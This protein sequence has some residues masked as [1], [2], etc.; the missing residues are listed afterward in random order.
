[1]KQ[2]PSVLVIDD[3]ENMLKM[4]STLLRDS[5]EVL[6]CSSGEEGL[7]SFRKNPTDLVVTDIRMPDVT[8]MEIL[9]SVKRISPDTEV[10]LM[11]AYAQVSQ[12][13][14]AMKAGAY[15]YVTKPF[16]P[17]DMVL[18]LQ[19]ALER[20]RL[21]ERTA[22]LEKEVEKR[23]GFSEIIGES[24]AMQRA[25]ELARKAVASDTTV[26]LTGES[27]TGKELF[28]R[29]IHYSGPRHK[30]RF[31][32]INCAAMPK[33]LIESE[34]FGHVK[35]AFSGASRDKPGLFE[36]ADGGTLLLDEITELPHDMQAKINR[37]LEQ[38]EVRRVGDTRDRPV[39]VRVIA[40]SNHDLNSATER[41]M[42]REDLYFRLNVFPIHLPPLR[43]REGDVPLLL[44]HFMREFAGEDAG[45]YHIEPEA[46]DLLLRYSWPG[47]VR[48]LR[49]AIERALALCEDKRITSDLF[50]L[51]AGGEL[52]ATAVAADLPY[53][54]AMDRMTAQ[55]QREYLLA[56]LKKYD[57]NVTRAAEHAGIERESFHR[58]M[59]KCSVSSDDLKPSGGTT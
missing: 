20:K 49:N 56:V 18:T 40:S 1:M 59:R 46:K 16:E 48:E 12:A 55:S 19:K 44:S 29:A 28:A 30:N 13:V 50:A 17:D 37:A 52:S 54:E 25:F 21:R 10:V 15:D 53:R 3:R 9:R 32:A 2:E 43:E 8:G 26:L 33:E 22:V 47:N 51:H 14:E 7:E 27:G 36:E 45:S 5:F 38:R 11:T 39:D 42:L 34:L 41:S 31:V 24:E 6:T 58:L 23:F 4:M 35:G 57:G